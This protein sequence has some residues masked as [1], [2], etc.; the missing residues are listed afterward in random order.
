MPHINS[1]GRFFK[2]IA[3][4]VARQFIELFK[5]KIT[6]LH[7]SWVERDIEL[8]S[9]SG[10]K[11]SGHKYLYAIFLFCLWAGIDLTVLWIVILAL[12]YYMK[13]CLSG[14]W[15]IAGKLKYIRIM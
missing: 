6:I 9:A 1:V 8:S 15:G 2:D 7:A 11:P 3:S 13:S 14:A 10:S 4:V 12:P 5:A